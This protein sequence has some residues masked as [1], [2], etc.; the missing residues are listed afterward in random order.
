MPEPNG[1][2]NRTAPTTQTD[3]PVS[4]RRCLEL[5]G[6]MLMSGVGVGAASARDSESAAE[7]DD[8]VTGR[9]SEPAGDGDAND[10]PV[11]GGGTGYEH[12]VGP[13]QADVTVGTRSELRDALGSASSGDV[14]YVA[15]DA[16]IDMGGAEWSVPEGVTLASDRG[17][18]GAP[19]GHLQTTDLPWPMFVVRA[20]ARVTGLRVS[21]Q[22]D[23]YVDLTDGPV[24][25]GLQVAD[26]GVE[27][28][29]NEVFG[30]SHAAIRP[31]SDTHVHH[32]DVH[33]N[34]MGGLGYGV[35]VTRGEPL[36]EYNYFNYNRHSVAGSG[37]CG[38]TARYNHFGPETVDHVIDQHEP[39]GTT[40]EIHHNTVEATEHVQNGGEPE[41]VAIRGTPDGVAS[42]HHNW[43]YNADEPKSTPADWD[44]SAITQVNT[45]DWANVEY[46]A[47]HYGSDEPADDVGCP[48]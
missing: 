44:G 24:S 8:D 42:I 17:I 5:T 16:T 20:N 40:M 4:R 35:S 26:S 32:N 34:P 23:E 3:L 30:F 39:G 38:Y 21:G 27:I 11:V 29:N 1:D 36:I 22:Y 43:F 37:N 18:D 45:G 6:L 19:G 41:A 28:D 47:N 31:F 14:V 46:E 13:E 7:A 15:G 2:R 9:A 12:T 25:I 33:H 10:A 48:R